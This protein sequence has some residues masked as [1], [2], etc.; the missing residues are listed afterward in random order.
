V[1]HGGQARLGGGLPALWAYSVA[2]AAL[3]LPICAVAAVAGGPVRITPDLVV[4]A[5]ASTVLHTSYAALV[6]QAYLH[7]DVNQVYPLS[8]G[9]APVLV[10][11]A[12]YAVLRQ[13]LAPLEWVG[14]L[15]MGLAAAALLGDGVEDSRRASRLPVLWAGAVA[16]AV[17]SYTLLDGWAVA[18]RHVDPLPYCA[19]G[20]ILQTALVTALVRH[21]LPEGVRQ[22]RT[23]SATV[24]KLAALIP[25]STLLALYAVQH[26]PVSLVA[27]I[28]STSVI[29]AALAAC[30]YLHE[31][32][33]WRRGTATTLVFAGLLAMVVAS[34]SH[35]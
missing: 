3:V 33:G 20:C 24:A 11:L 22:L 18:T 31:R 1:E 25:L 10:A 13:P 15:L 2:A 26:A 19:L 5:A 27:A 29:W 14:V 7:C 16:I 23:H 17:A 8:R 35:E 12:G 32:L 4:L 6:Q 34:T 21:R 30:L 9:L 28:R